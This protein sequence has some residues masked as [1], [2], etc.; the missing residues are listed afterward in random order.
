MTQLTF[1]VAAAVVWFLLFTEPVVKADMM[2]GSNG[3]LESIYNE[4]MLQ[5]GDFEPGSISAT[6]DLLGLVWKG[7][8]LLVE[9]T[10]T[11]KGAEALLAHT[12]EAYGV[13]IIA[14]SDYTCSCYLPMINYPAF[15]ADDNVKAARPSMPRTQQQAPGLKLQSFQVDHHCMEGGN[16]KH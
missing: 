6:S 9:V 3:S 4:M 2:K 8:S 15:I 11:A 7:K 1:A 5:G 14:C 10:A 12:V 16:S 13:E